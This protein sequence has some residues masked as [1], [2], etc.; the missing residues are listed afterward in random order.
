MLWCLESLT[1]CGLR[2]FGLYSEQ[3]ICTAGL[4]RVVMSVQVSVA[5][6][7]SAESDSESRAVT[8]YLVCA[9]NKSSAG[10]A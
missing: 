1:M 10:Q 5:W 7:H 3:I 4:R 2:F 6:G 8:D 9:V